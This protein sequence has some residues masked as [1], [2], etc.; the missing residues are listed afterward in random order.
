MI[1]GLL[2]LLGL[3]GTAC[4]RKGD[5]AENARRIERLENDLRTLDGEAREAKRKIADLEAE[6]DRAKEERLALKAQI[7]S[8]RAAQIGPHA[9]AGLPSRATTSCAGMV[10]PRGGGRYDVRPGVGDI[11]SQGG[12]KMTRIVPEISGG[13]SVG[14]KMFGIRPGSCVAE[15]GF[16][17]GDSLRRINGHSVASPDDALETYTRLRGAKRVSVDIVRAGKPTTLVYVVVP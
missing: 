17:N 15:L 10:K 16:K 7:E 12:T 4:A 13:K 2:A 14:I 9:D 5:V 1:V 8:L 3:L 11:V 6:R